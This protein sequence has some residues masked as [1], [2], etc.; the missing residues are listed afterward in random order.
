MEAK[1]KKILLTGVNGF[2]GSHLLEYL[3]KEIKNDPQI[4]SVF[5]IEILCL[6]RE[7]SKRKRNIECSDL[8][9][10]YKCINYNEIDKLTDLFDEIEYIFHIAGVTKGMTRQD[11]INGNVAPTENILKALRQNLEQKPRNDE[12]KFKRFVYIS[13]LAASG[14]SHTLENPKK[15]NDIQTPIEFYGESKLLAEKVV[16]KYS[17]YIPTTIIRPSAVYGER[18]SDFLKIYKMI[19]N[20]LNL[21]YQNKENY[22]SMIYVRDLVEGIIKA[23]LNDKCI[24]QTYNLTN[25]EIVQWKDFQNLI[26]KIF[27]KK[28]LITINIPKFILKFLVVLG[29]FYTKIFH[30][31]SILNKQKI[32]MSFQKYWICS[33]EKA[34]KD[35]GFVAKTN[36]R[37]GLKKTLQY[38]F[39]EIYE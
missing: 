30:K 15:E 38:H 39:K 31:K 33:G 37:D 5:G 3:L 1:F 26:A 8:N 2:V 22:M 6:L 32:K 29:Q 21:F 7:E 16:E 14:P 27:H 34:K 18:D 9:I 24:G 25:F 35:F 23:S 4:K 20:S 28:F 12:N 19:H 13:S 11:F 10:K 36:L 17:K